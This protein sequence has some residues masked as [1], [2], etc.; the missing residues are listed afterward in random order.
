MLVVITSTRSDVEVSDVARSRA[1]VR[2][3]VAVRRGVDP[4]GDGAAGSGS[5]R[6]AL[7]GLAGLLTSQGATDAVNLDG[8]GSS[9]M[10]H[11]APGDQR[12]SVVNTPSE[13][14]TRLVPNALGVFG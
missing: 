13:D 6:S 14:A 5:C 8:G 10:I 9:T 12:V 11:R 4:S 7:A 2:T 3:A 1:R